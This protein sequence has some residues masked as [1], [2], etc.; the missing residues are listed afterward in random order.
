[1]IIV[2]DGSSSQAQIDRLRASLEKR[3]KMITTSTV[4]FSLKGLLWCLEGEKCNGKRK[5]TLWGRKKRLVLV[6]YGW[7]M[8]SRERRSDPGMWM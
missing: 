2:L 4:G 5:E 7:V 1:M 6:Q 3:A 8:E